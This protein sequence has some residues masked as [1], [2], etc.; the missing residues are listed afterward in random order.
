MCYLLLFI[1]PNLRLTVSRDP[2]IHVG[3]SHEGCDLPIWDQLC[4]SPAARLVFS[5]GHCEDTL[6]SVILLPDRKH[7]TVNL[8]NRM[9]F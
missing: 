4:E 8:C 6:V 3:G 7:H 1:Y 5:S 2:G 9:T